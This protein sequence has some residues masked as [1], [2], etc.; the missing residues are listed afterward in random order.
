MYSPSYAQ[1]GGFYDSFFIG[2]ANHFEHMSRFY[3][4]LINKKFKNTLHQNYNYFF[5]QLINSE[6]M[7]AYYVTINNITMLSI[8]NIRF[9]R[10]RYDGWVTDH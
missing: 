6:P 1:F 2:N 9:H 7:F 4:Y 5:R 10:I 3:D 8:L